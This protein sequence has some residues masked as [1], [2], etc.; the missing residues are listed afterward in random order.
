MLMTE[1]IVVKKSKDTFL[2]WGFNF[3]SV[4]CFVPALPHRVQDSKYTA[5]S[6]TDTIQMDCERMWDWIIFLRS[7]LLFQQYT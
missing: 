7:V 2:S 6:L 4:V 1:N 5:D 3:E